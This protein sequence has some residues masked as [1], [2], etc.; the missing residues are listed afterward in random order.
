MSDSYYVIE[1]SLGYPSKSIGVILCFSGG[2]DSSCAALRLTKAGEYPL[3]L[4][5]IDST[6]QND[7]KTEKRV[8]ELQS[9]L[10]HSFSWLSIRAQNFYEQ[11]L[12]IPLITSPSCLS[13][14]FVKLSIAI[15]IAKKHS[16]TKVAAGFT[17]YQS[18]WIEQS[19]TAI[20]EIGKLL[21]EYEL[22]LVLPVQDILS[23]EAACK[24]LLDCSITPESLEPIC[25]CA[26]EGTKENA[27]PIDIQSDISKLAIP[28]REF[29]NLCFQEKI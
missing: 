15:I 20:D 1:K 25:H 24:I 3:L 6:V 22:S 12:N 13:C 26:T 23:K 28:C 8:A 29:I 18:T 27:N 7:R 9:T 14:F 5:V 11:I 19:P 10:N 16:V 17:S 2:R 21:K 4:T